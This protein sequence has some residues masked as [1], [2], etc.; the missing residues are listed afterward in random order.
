MILSCVSFS[1]I[2]LQIAHFH[3]PSRACAAN[4]VEDI[5]WLEM[6]VV[7]ALAVILLHDFLQDIKCRQAPDPTTVKTKETEPGNIKVRA[8]A[9][10]RHLGKVL[11]HQPFQDLC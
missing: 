1:L 11:M 3:A 7:R 9:G 2:R 5:A 6:P 4:Q 10:F 8:A